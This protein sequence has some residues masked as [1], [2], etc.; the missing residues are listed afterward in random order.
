MQGPAKAGSF[1][2]ITYKFMAIPTMRSTNLV[3][4]L[5]LLSARL[6]KFQK[7]PLPQCRSSNNDFP[8]PIAQ[9]KSYSNTYKITQ[10]HLQDI[11]I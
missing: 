4:I 5:L 2:S 10:A 1:L 11:R 6:Q 7:R 8:T 9:P 3:H